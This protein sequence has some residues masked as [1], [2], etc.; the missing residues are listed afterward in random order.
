MPSLGYVLVL[1][2]TGG[3]AELVILERGVRRGPEQEPHVMQRDYMKH[4]KVHDV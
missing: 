3:K 4:R 1:F 2:N